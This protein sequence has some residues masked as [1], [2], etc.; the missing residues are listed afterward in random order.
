MEGAMPKVDRW[1]NGVPRVEVDQRARDARLR[2][3]RLERL[4]VPRAAMT[5]FWLRRV[6]CLLSFDQYEDPQGRQ[7]RRPLNDQ[8]PSRMPTI[9]KVQ[10]VGEAV[11]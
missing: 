11:P 9:L 5:V 8:R 4:L 10:H 2:L 7:T 6:V 3:E 1:Y